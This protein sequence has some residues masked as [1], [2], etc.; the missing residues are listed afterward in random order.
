VEGGEPEKIA[1]AFAPHSLSWFP[2]GSWIAYV[3]GNENFIFGTAGLGNV[4]PS[5]LWTVSTTESDAEPLLLRTDT[6][7]NVSPVWTSD[8]K[9][10]LFVS[11]Q[12]GSRDVYRMPISGSGTPSGP[13]VRLST[14]LNAHTISLSA[15]GESLAYSVFTYDANI[16]SIEIPE[17]AAVSI[18]EAQPITTGAQTI[19]F[20]GVSPDGQWLAFDSNRS[21]NQD[22]YK[23]P[24][25]GG[26]PQQLTTHPS[27][28]FFPSWSPS[29]EEIAFYSYRSGNRDIYVMPADG[30]S[31]QQV[32]DDPA[33]DLHPEWS[34]DG[35]RLLIRSDRTGRGELYVISRDEET[36]EWGMPRQLTLDGAGRSKWSP[37]GRLVAYASGRNSIRL[38]PPEGGDSQVL[39]RYQESGASPRPPSLLWS[40]DGRTVYYK[41]FDVEGRPSIWS[42]PVSGGVPKLLIRFDDPSRLSSRGEFATDGERF[43]F[44]IERRES[45]IGVMELIY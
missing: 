24:L 29:G 9:H 5:S 7:L 28:D 3:S 26:E 36:S 34:P 22:I 33:I 14:G 45:D 41:A 12:D 21:G 10:L 27:N 40:Q 42:V 8:G 35:S 30:G 4:A 15:D 32:T 13:P 31:L 6:Y 1:D 11:N 44:T 2:D 20:L 38:I 25:T 39:L 18:S 17:E 43:F 37:D 19:Q 23:V 16:W